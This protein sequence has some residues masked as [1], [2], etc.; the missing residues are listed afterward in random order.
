[1]EKN[2][3]YSQ[4]E[5]DFP[6]LQ[7]VDPGQQM[8]KT[9]SVQYSTE[10]QDFVSGL[11]KKANRVYALVNA[12]TAGEYFGPNKNGD[13]FPEDALRKHHK[14]FV[15]NGHVY[16]HHVNKDPKKSLGDILYSMYNDR[17]KRVELVISLKTDHDKVKDLL[18]DL[19]RGKMP[20]TSMGTRVPYD[21]CSICGHKAKTRKHY[22]NHLKNNMNAILPDGRRVYAN[23]LTPKF[24]DISIVTIPADP[25]S[26]IMA[27]L[28]GLDKVANFL[29]KKSEKSVKAEINKEIE[30]EISHVSEDP[31]EL[32]IGS[33]KRLS[34]EQIEKLSEY[35]FENVLSTF[36]GMRIMPLREDF[37]KLA[38]YTMGKRELADILE[39]EGKV[40]QSHPHTFEMPDDVSLDRFNEKIAK[41]FSEEDIQQMSLTKP[42]VVGRV[43]EKVATNLPDN[44]AA[45][46]TYKGKEYPPG[47]DPRSYVKR[48]FADL[49]SD[50]DLGP[51]QVSAVKNPI[52]P[53]VT[54]GALY[55]GYAKYFGK[56]SKS[57]FTKFLRKSP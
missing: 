33:Q 13:Y 18:E 15:D 37:Q 6:L 11:E 17:M 16:S 56:T 35:P 23:N 27:V 24:F 51:D 4:S 32:I 41:V 19:A 9:A 36:L 48:F 54:L 26:N 44:S 12:L 10:I 14:S 20:A 29:D 3:Q 22:C 28:G 34:Q 1:M 21:V 57:E 38:L 8:E 53:M 42:L 39:K 5:Y 25:T 40:F 2:V 52:A 31:D 50:D 49:P 30:G 7:F 45:G 43:L 55:A 47:V 46:I